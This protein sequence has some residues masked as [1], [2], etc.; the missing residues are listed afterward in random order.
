MNFIEN[1]NR[2]FGTNFTTKSTDAEINAVLADFAPIS[3]QLASNE[4]Q[5]G[6]LTTQLNA[7]NEEIQTLADSLGE[8][9]TS[10]TAI[11]SNV[12]SKVSELIEGATNAFNDKITEVGTALNDIKLG[13]QGEGVAIGKVP[14]Q[15]GGDE[16]AEGKQPN[17]VA[18]GNFL[19]DLTSGKIIK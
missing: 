5:T 17:K 3:E 12:T 2:V 15:G 11:E 4:K 16:G 13:K 19:S 10:L 14:L 18:M 7:A 1:L 8:I 9:K 6:D